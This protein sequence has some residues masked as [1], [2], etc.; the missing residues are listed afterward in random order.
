[1]EAVRKAVQ[2]ELLAS[3]PKRVCIDRLR[4][5]WRILVS[6]LCI[7]QENIIPERVPSLLHAGIAPVEIVE[8]P[9]PVYLPDGAKAVSIVR[10]PTPESEEDD[11][12]EVIKLKRFTGY[13]TDDDST[14][15]SSPVRESRSEPVPQPPA[16]AEFDVR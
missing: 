6:H 2:L 11:F 1:M 14:S 10:V 13:V 12:E 4:L 5:S 3:V 8:P 9:P 16:A 15:S 7:H